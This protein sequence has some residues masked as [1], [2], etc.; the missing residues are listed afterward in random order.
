M[1]DQIFNKDTC[2]TYTENYRNDFVGENEITVSITLREYRNLITENAK[3][4]EEIRLREEET[5]KARME[6]DDAKRQLQ[7]FLE[8]LGIEEGGE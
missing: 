3:H 4:R 1:A 2:N 6:R 8:K 5:A 7:G